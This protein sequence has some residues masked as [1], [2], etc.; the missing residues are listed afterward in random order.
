MSCKYHKINLPEFEGW[1]GCQIHVSVFAFKSLR[2]GNCL[3]SSTSTCLFPHNNHLNE[4][5]LLASIELYENTNFC[6]QYPALLESLKVH[7][8][9]Y[10][11]FN[12]IFSCCLF[13][14][15]FNSF[16]FTDIIKSF[17]DK[18]IYNLKNGQYCSLL[19]ILPLSTIIEIQINFIYSSIGEKKF[20]L[21]FNNVIK[22]RQCYCFAVNHV[23]TPISIIFSIFGIS[24]NCAKFIANHFVPIVQ[25]SRKVLVKRHASYNSCVKLPKTT[26]ITKNYQKRP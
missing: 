26:K 7:S 9:V 19:C 24:E 3:Y 23:T 6:Y 12:S 14:K 25:D 21:L 2:N 15:C 5:R 16:S 4:L 20:R 18:A 13:Q 11:D 22:R 8:N 10:L 17:K 1:N